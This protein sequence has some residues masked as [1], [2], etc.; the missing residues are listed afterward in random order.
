MPSP[1]SV[2]TSVSSVTSPTPH[3]HLAGRIAHA[4]DPAVEQ[5]LAVAQH[6]END[7]AALG[8]IRMVLQEIIH[9]DPGRKEFVFPGQVIP[10]PAGGVGAKA[11]GK[12][13]SGDGEGR[14][15]DG[16]VRLQRAPP[17]EGR[18]RR[19][20]AQRLQARVGGRRK[21]LGGA[22]QRTQS[23]DQE[24]DC[25]KVDHKRLPSLLGFRRPERML[26]EA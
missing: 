20:P 25:L 23:G 9:A 7:A 11:P 13:A 8:R 21:V 10:D 15:G 17:L 18:V 24:D 16:F 4:H 6:L 12:Y 3:L 2:T 1:A 26:R 22:A 5:K 14:A 19:K